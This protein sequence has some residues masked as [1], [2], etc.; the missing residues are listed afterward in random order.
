M[1]GTTRQTPLLTVGNWH[2]Q[3]NKGGWQLRLSPGASGV[4]VS[5]STARVF[6]TH[7]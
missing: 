6:H 3:K 7:D 4:R 5:K 2:Q 1:L